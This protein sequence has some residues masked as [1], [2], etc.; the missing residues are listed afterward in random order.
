MNLPVGRLFFMLPVTSE[1][2]WSGLWRMLYKDG[3]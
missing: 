1:R 2:E 3:Q